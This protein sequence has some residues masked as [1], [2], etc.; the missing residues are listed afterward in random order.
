MK[1]IYQNYNMIYK[2]FLDK[3]RPVVIK[4]FKNKF[5]WENETLVYSILKDKG[6]PIAD[7]I[8]WKPLE[9]M[10]SFL[11][12]PTANTLLKQNNHIIDFDK[13]I[14]FLVRLQR[15]KDNR[16]YFFGDGKK[17]FFDVAKSLYKKKLFPETF[18]YKLEKIALDYQPQTNVFCHGDFR[19]ENIFYS[20]NSVSGLIDFE[21]SGIS[22]PNKDLA[23]L[24]ISSVRLNKSLKYTLK[25]LFKGIDYFDKFSFFY[26]L[27]YMNLMILNNPLIKKKVDWLQ[28]LE[29]MIS[30][31]Y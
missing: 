19:L 10:Y 17:S 15:I 14:N 26:W 13:I 6:F 18:L 11:D 12:L 25:S 31:V 30:N 8:S 7:L 28:N 23:Y 27:V 21:F 9:N 4:R 29:E 20:N 16:F 22:D 1:K 24:W 2:G 3:K 5:S